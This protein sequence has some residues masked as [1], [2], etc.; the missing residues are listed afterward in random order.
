MLPYGPLATSIQPTISTAFQELFEE[1]PI[2]MNWQST[3]EVLI[4]DNWRMAHMRPDIP[5]SAMYRTLERVFVKEG[6]FA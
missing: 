3:E 5:E 2:I 4:L 6:E 1:E